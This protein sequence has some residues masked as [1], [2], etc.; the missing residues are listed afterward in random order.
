[1]N[2]E[3]YLDL[4]ICMIDTRLPDLGFGKP[5][6]WLSLSSPQCRAGCNLCGVRLRGPTAIQS[7]THALLIHDMYT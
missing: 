5:L 6:G 4:Q 2:I 1:M 3:K 7:R